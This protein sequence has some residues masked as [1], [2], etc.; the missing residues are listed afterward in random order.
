M[1][2][3][4]KSCPFP[5]CFLI[6]PSINSL[7][8]YKH[9]FLLV[10]TIYKLEATYKLLVTVYIYSYKHFKVIMIQQLQAAVILQ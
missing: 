1:Y 6:E 5:Q 10:F 7:R 8:V 4:M 9:H 2:A 3:Y